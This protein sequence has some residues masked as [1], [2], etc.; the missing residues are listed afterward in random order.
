MRT[1]VYI[2]GFN[3]FY[4][5]LK[6]TPHKWLNLEALFD[7]LL[8]KNQIVKIRYFTALVDSRPNDPDLPIR[9]ATYARAL[10]TLPRVEIHRGTFLSSCVRA[11]EVEVDPVTGRPRKVNGHPVIKLAN[12]GL[13]VMKWVFKSEEKGS[14]V[15][16]AAHL[17]RDAYRGDCDCAV[18]VSND[19]DLLTPIRMVQADQKLVVGLVPPR[20]RGSVELKALATFTKSIRQHQL[21]SA[22]FPDSFVDASGTITKPIGW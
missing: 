19:S 17:L 20:E 22:Q 6:G 10:A 4:G 13:P 3:L 14:D 1:Y 2:D 12:S 16:L 18:V 7:N 21:V 8:P 5:L 11:P 9:Q 15:N